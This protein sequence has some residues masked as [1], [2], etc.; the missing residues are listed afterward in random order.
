MDDADGAG[1]A[2]C[3]GAA[4]RRS[5]VVVTRFMIAFVHKGLRGPSGL[6]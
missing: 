1:V 5:A 2:A 3:C 4:R 6:S